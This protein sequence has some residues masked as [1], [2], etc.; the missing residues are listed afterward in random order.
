MALAA[1]AVD[2][3]G[4]IPG[5]PLAAAIVDHGLR[6]GSREEAER[7]ALR[8]AALGL[9]ARVLEW[10]GAKPVAALQE[11]ARAARYGLLSE[12]AREDGARVVM[13]AHHAD[14]QAETILFRLLRGS[15]PAGLAGMAASASR[16]GIEIAR[17]FLAFP[18]ARLLA[19]LAA[20]EIDFACD[21]SNENPRFARARL[22]ALAPLLAAE[23]GDAALFA[24]L[25]RRVR[26]AE[27]A[28]EAARDAARREV[29]REGGFDA[30]AF[31]ALPQELRVRLLRAAV[32]EIGAAALRLDRLEALETRLALARAEGRG[33]RLTL[34]RA[35]VVLRGERLSFRPAPPRRR[36]PGGV[37]HSHGR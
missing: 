37:E 35:L 12:A 15:G 17:P 3:R 24:R 18:K 16:D 4:R 7:A 2:W 8:C 26:R 9:P 6:A 10:R 22:R 25:A 29:A 19:Y 34:G 1:A 23:G 5:P 14:D 21:P 20:R 30:P 13:T 27:A 28:L 32:G 11:H 33:A 31:F 36:E